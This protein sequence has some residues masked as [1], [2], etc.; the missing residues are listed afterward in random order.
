MAKSKKNRK[1]SPPSKS[2]LAEGKQNAE[3]KEAEES[4]EPAFALDL[5][6][7]CEN[8]LDSLNI[9]IALTTYQA[10][11][12][13]FFGIKEDKTV[14][15][16][17]RN[18]GRCLGLAI[19]PDRQKILCT[20]DSQI[21]VFYN[22]LPEGFK[23]DNVTD[24]LYVPQATYF[25]GDLDIHDM[26]LDGDGNLIF[27]NTLFNCVATVEERY[28]F[29]PYWQPPFITAMVAEDR[30]HLN[31][32]A[33]RDGKLK[34]VTMVSA[35][36][37]LDAWRDNR[38]DGGIV[39]DVESNEIVARGLSMPHSPRYY[40]GKLW[41][42]NSGRGEFGFINDRGEFEAV[43]FCPGYLRGLD[44]YNEYAFIGLSLPR[45]NKTF[46]GLPL[47]DILKQRQIEARCG[48]YAVNIETGTIVHWFKISGIM[49]ELYDV[50]CIPGFKT[51][52]A[53]SPLSK[54]DMQ[55]YISVGGD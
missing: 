12:I 2:P 36:D 22:V 8:W 47:D 28:S 7:N 14:W 17:N 45:E 1:S 33:M 55:R 41:L 16:H 42:L 49:T 24:A 52:A 27:I 53:I 43:A 25:T 48:I 40:R 26:A 19:S 29:M 21:Y 51:P 38:S 46:S 6:R 9:S 23:S 39:M 11:K 54:T 44:F 15:V 3:I 5:S 13:M 4:K 30:C 34:Y 32:M 37:T 35:T 50:A 18:I 20:S 10:G 31:G